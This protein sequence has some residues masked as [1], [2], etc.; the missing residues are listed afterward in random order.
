[1]SEIT[2]SYPYGEGAFSPEGHNSN[3]DSL[4]RGVNSGALDSSNLT[5]NF[6]IQSGM[7]MREQSVFSRFDHCLD[8]T[9]YYGEG[10]GHESTI[11]RSFGRGQDS[12]LLSATDPEVYTAVSGAGFRWYQPYDASTGI[13]QW[14][15]FTS[16][17]RWIVKDANANR[18][19]SDVFSIMPPAGSTGGV[20]ADTNIVCTIVAID[21]PL[22]SVLPGE[23]LRFMQRNINYPASKKSTAPSV[24]SSKAHKRYVQQEAHSALQFDQHV[25]FSSKWGSTHP[26]SQLKKGWYEMR[27]MVMIEQPQQFFHSHKNVHLRFGNHFRKHNLIFNDK[28]SFGIRNARVVTFL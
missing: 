26:L 22:G 5:T 12:T 16:H 20:T 24:K 28:I 27:V 1:M 4:Q 8:T 10:M 17:N 23:S 15:F 11:A 14:S 9:T 18:D 21:T 6:K 3:I 2:F 13:L 19:D 25:I 7:I